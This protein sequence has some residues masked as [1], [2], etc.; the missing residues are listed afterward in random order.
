ML[1]LRALV[2][3]VRTKLFGWEGALRLALFHFW[4]GGTES[5]AASPTILLI[6]PDITNSD[7]Q[8]SLIKRQTTYAKDQRGR[9]TVKVLT[10]V[11]VLFLVLVLPLSVKAGLF[12]TWFS[13]PETISSPVVKNDLSDNDLPLLTA[14]I[15]PNP[16]L[17]RGGA[18]IV[19]EDD[20]LVS[21]GPVGKD[22]IEAAKTGLGEIRVYTVRGGDSLSQIAQM[23][24]VTTNTI[25]WA[26]DIKK[27]T[28]I[29]PGD[30]LVILPVAGV[31]HTVRKGDT[32]SGIAKKYGGNA[33][34]ILAYNQLES[35]SDLKIGETIIIPGGALRK[36]APVRVSKVKPAR[37]NTKPAGRSGWLINPA[38]GSIKTQGVH[39][40]NA[41]DL[42]GVYG[43][44][45]YAAAAGKV[46]VSRASGWNGGYGHYVVIKH[47]NGVQTLYAHLMRND[48]VVGQ[49]VSQGQVIGGMG[50]TGKSTGTHVHFEVR[51]AANPF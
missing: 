43:S 29:R 51:G 22:E 3:Y 38:P 11:M 15:N 21:T 31:R 35:A 34:E 40:Y 32:I 10:E 41:V 4:R 14:I 49:Q 1:Y 46:I 48:V 8:S 37:V 27:A 36:T 7:E 50:S 12:S 45:I 30:T 28:A 26:N 47:P 6:K 23:F 18:D 39:G 42:A 19:V 24:G 17:A 20:A 13:S 25:M 33:D 16:K 44:P 2:K 5:A 9:V